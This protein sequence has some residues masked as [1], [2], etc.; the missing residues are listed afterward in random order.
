MEPEKVCFVFMF[1]YTCEYGVIQ[2]FTVQFSCKKLYSP[3]CS[4]KMSK[5]SC[6]KL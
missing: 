3:V 2:L 4:S 5:Y 6:F 1:K